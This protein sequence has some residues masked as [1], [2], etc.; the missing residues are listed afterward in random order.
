MYTRILVIQDRFVEK[1]SK[2]IQK[3]QKRGFRVVVEERK[4]TQSHYRR[5]EETNGEEMRR[6][7]RKGIENQRAGE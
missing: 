2:R 6:N 7:S 4:R 1:R 5:F 3:F